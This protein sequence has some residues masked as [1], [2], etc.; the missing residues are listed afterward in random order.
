MS[1]LIFSTFVFL[2]SAKAICAWGEKGAWGLEES[3]RIVHSPAFPPI[4]VVDT[5]GA[6]DTFNAGILHALNRGRTVEEA[7]RLGCQVA[8]QKVGRSGFKIDL[9]SLDHL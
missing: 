5:L 7:L 8:G 4:R 6:G 9:A 3:G 2:S 1:E